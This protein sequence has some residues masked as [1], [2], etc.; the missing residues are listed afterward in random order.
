M[1]RSLAVRDVESFKF[2]SRTT[3]EPERDFQN[4]V[5][6]R[7]VDSWGPLTS[8]L[9]SRGNSWDPCR[10]QAMLPTAAAASQITPL[11]STLCQPAT[12]ITNS[13]A[14]DTRKMHRSIDS[15]AWTPDGRRCLTGSHQGEIASW[16]SLSFKLESKLQA[17]EAA[18]T[19][20]RYS[21]N[22]NW[23]VTSDGNGRIKY[24]KGRN[25]LQ[26]DFQSHRE[27]VKCT[28][29]A[30]SSVKFVTASTDSTLKVWNFTTGQ[31]DRT[32]SGHARDVLSCDWHASAS[33]IVSG[34]KDYTARLWDA[35]VGGDSLS[36]LEG[37]M[38][39]VTSVQWHSNGNLILS[40]ARDSQ[41]KL[42][43]TRT[44]KEVT[45][46]S[47]S[48]API[49]CATWHPIHSDMFVSG[50]HDG[51]IHFWSA[52]HRA[53]QARIAG[54][55]QGPLWSLAWHP[56]GHLL[57]SGGGDSCAKFWC[58]SRPGDAFEEKFADRPAGMQLTAD[59]RSEKLLSRTLGIPGIAE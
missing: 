23:L 20:M 18:I 22:E 26:K 51:S 21:H 30:P 55:H 39:E 45:S 48:E 57:A 6:R 24:W 52:T 10:F 3:C 1:E 58:R 42:W 15:L 56:E 35:R 36:S 17:H 25:E 44:M 38:N 32:M 11:T 43:D 41:I 13:F 2:T 29:F 16:N 54:A 34:S 27:S 59:G 33:T 9:Q 19:C 46:F 7:T 4:S 8:M 37:H 53:P 5:Q 40:A 49:N 31:E 47:G 28:S 14:G 50:G 12:S